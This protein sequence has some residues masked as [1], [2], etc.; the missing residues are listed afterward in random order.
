MAL[1]SV[2]DTSLSIKYTVK[3][4]PNIAYSHIRLFLLITKKTT[5]I[6]IASNALNNCRYD[7]I[8]TCPGVALINATND[9][10]TYAIITVNTG[11]T[12][13]LALLYCSSVTFYSSCCF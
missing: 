4:D 6:M 10:N 9:K 8:V 5:L 13:V 11:N 3:A 2:V 1:S 12:T 7:A